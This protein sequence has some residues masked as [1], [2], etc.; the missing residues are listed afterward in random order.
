MKVFIDTP[1]LV[2]L[3]VLADSRNRILYENFYID[4]LTKYKLYTELMC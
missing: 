1:L 2:Y 3:N 4:A